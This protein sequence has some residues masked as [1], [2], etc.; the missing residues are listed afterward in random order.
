MG[1]VNYLLNK[2]KGFLMTVKK[3]ICNPVFSYL[4]KDL[5]NWEYNSISNGDIIAISWKFHR[6]KS[7]IVRWMTNLDFM[8]KSTP[9]EFH[10]KVN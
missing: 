2:K 3:N 10:I 5:K 4:E 8:C 9:T 1:S 7:K 6:N